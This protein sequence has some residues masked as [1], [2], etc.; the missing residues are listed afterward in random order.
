[1]ATVRSLSP[2]FLF[3]PFGVKPASV[4]TVR[5]LSPLFLFRPFGVK[6]ASLAR[7]ELSFSFPAVWRKTCFVG[8]YGSEP[9]SS[10]FLFR[11]FG[12]KPASSVATVRSLSPFFFSGRLA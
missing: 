7:S 11:P 12:V 3:R 6:P 1:M 2:L 10:F 5:S 9:F 4:A 8:G